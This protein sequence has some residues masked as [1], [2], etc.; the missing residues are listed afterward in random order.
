MS[1]QTSPNAD[2]YPHRHLL[3]IE[4][5]QPHEILALLDRAE[6]AVEI[7]RQVEKKKLSCGAA[8]RSTSSSKPRRARKSSFELAGKRLGADVMNMSVSSV[9]GEEGRDADR[10][11]RDAERHAPGY[12]VVRHHAAGAVHLL[13]RRSAAP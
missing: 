3:G 8:R 13:A 9:F 2:A 7:S 4:G 6:S 11:G 1:A 12:A 10:H 5:L